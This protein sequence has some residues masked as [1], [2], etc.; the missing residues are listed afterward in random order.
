MKWQQKLHQQLQYNYCHPLIPTD[1]HCLDILP[2]SEADIWPVGQDVLEYLGQ[3]IKNLLPLD[4]KC[5]TV[6]MTPFERVSFNIK[7]G[8]VTYKNDLH[9]YPGVSRALILW[10]A[11]KSL[12]MLSTSYPCQT[13]D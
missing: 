9:I 8:E 10:K 3:S 5:R 7:L 13:A 4:I 11:A 2:D 6:S 1:I 12:S